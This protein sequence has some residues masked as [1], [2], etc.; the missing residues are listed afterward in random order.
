MPKN[1]KEQ[2]SSGNETKHVKQ[3]SAIVEFSLFCNAAQ[4]LLYGNEGYSVF[5]L[6]NAH[7]VQ[8]ENKKISIEHF[9][10]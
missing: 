8:E 4:A 10:A 5:K 7:R 3:S 6:I 1:L 2:R 9:K